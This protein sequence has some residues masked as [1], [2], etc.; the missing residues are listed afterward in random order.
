MD[1]QLKIINL[2]DDKISVQITNYGATITSIKL[3][4]NKGVLRD[5]V[6]GYDTI[7]EYKKGTCYFG[8][9]I[10]R[11]G[12][13]IGNAR[14]NLNGKTIKVSNNEDEN[15]LH[16]GFNGFDKKV[17]KILNT[18]SDSVV[19]SYL[20]VEGEEGFPGNLKVNLKFSVS[21]GSIKIEYFAESDKDTIVNLTN[22]SYFNLSGEGSGDILDTKVYIDADFVSKVEKGLIPNGELISTENTPF[23]FK[24][25]KP[26]SQDIESDN[27][28]LKI[29]GGYDIN[30]LLNGKGFRKIASALSEK[31]GIRMNVYSDSVGVQFYSGNFLKG[32]QG[33]N[34]HVYGKRSGFCLETQSIPNSIN[35]EK[36]SPT[37]LRKGERYKTT[38]VYEFIVQDEQ[39][40]G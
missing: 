35:I 17:W 40:F 15:C 30:Y 11:V 9:T 27:E 13:R 5:V 6:L 4:D 19:M 18:K 2:E 34:G 10:G 31:T 14:F 1:K 8:A 7:E 20:S 37:I 25:E 21:N 33:K 39:S 29:C 16:G 3:K 12:N 22:H 26:V 24:K 28:Q 38:T 32:E 36:S 23:D